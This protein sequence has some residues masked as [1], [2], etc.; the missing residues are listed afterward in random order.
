MAE[1]IAD[2]DI[3]VNLI[4][5]YYETRAP[6]TK[7]TFPYVGMKTNFT[8]KDCNVDIAR[9]I[10][11]LCTEMQV[12]NLIHV[13]SLNA[14]EDSA[15][16]WARTKW[17]G[18]QAVKEAYPW[19]T[20]IRPAQLVGHEDRFLNWFAKASI[21]YPAVPLV[22]GGHALT[23]PV[24]VADVADVISKV[25]DTPEDFEGRTV[26]VFGPSDYTYKEIGEFVFD[27]TGQTKPLVDVPKSVMQAS[28]RVLQF[29]TLGKGP[30]ITP[31]L[32]ELWT[33]DFVP[34]MTEEEY[35]A[36]PQKDKILTMKDFGL[37]AT[38]IEK[39]AFDYLH[40][41]RDG[42]HFVLTEG[43]QGGGHSSRMFG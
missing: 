6:T 26:D 39:I 21:M 9:T 38:P 35:D 19:A 17:W 40:R 14:S 22:D 4:G 5:K 18:E 30:M 34:S 20:I 24:Y 27:I 31:D 33:E 41:Y 29:Q 3:V 15:S 25:I 12:D 2:A 7:D 23:Q 1:L 43:Y 32:V 37:A 8:F 36:Q 16:E 28:A 13:S 42:G 10:A 11:E